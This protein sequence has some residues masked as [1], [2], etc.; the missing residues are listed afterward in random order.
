MATPNNNLAEKT[1]AYRKVLQNTLTYRKAWTHSVKELIRANLSGF[2]KNSGLTGNVAVNSDMENLESVFLDFGRSSSGIGHSRDSAE[3]RNFMIKNN[4]G[5][6]YQQ[7]FN[8]KIMVMVHHPHIEGYGERKEP[9][10]VEIVTPEEVS[11][12]LILDHVGIMLDMLT[13]WEDF[14]DE[15]PQKKTV[16]NPI[17]FQHTVGPGESN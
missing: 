2:L 1:E 11:E 16:F 4:G 10:F 17:G 15:G 5:L 14:D 12:Q 9:Q 8:G 6:I 13:Q 3:I 7:L